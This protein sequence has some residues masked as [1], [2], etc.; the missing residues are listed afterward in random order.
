MPGSR[1]PRRNT[2]HR[3]TARRW[4]RRANWRAEQAREQMAYAATDHAD[5]GHPSFVRRWLFSTNHKD[6]GTLYLLTS[7]LAGVIGGALS[8]GVRMELQEP[9]MQIF[10]NPHN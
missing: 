9:G 7:I 3:P 5:H 8:V 2:R 4:W 10:S 6:I 1:K